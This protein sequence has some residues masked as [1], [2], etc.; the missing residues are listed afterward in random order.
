MMIDDNRKTVS[1]VRGTT[2]YGVKLCKRLNKVD[3]LKDHGYINF[4]ILGVCEQCHNEKKRVD[5]PTKDNMG[6]FARKRRSSR[7]MT[8]R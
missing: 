4:G 1:S 2:I 5:A 3:K 8:K 7:V 6:G